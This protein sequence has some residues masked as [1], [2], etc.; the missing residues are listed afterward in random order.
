MLRYIPFLDAVATLCVMATNEHPEHPL[1][2]RMRARGYRLT[3]QRR[4]ITSAF[5]EPGSVHLSAEEVWA[6]AQ[7]VVPETARATVYGTLR[8]LASAGLLSEVRV[9][10]GAVRY[11]PNVEAGHHH[12]VCRTCGRV[13][14]VYPNGVEAVTLDAPVQTDEVEMVFRGTCAGCQPQ[15]AR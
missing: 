14:D 1:T 13:E 6:R 7:R 3:P 8:E 2:S 12:F 4:A 10:G 15:E 9:D 11:D 5:A